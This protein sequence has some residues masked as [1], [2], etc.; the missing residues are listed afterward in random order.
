MP[1]TKQLLRETRDRIVPPPDVLGSLER[2]RHHR[3]QI[4]RGSALVVA[5]VVALLGLGGWFAVGRD[6]ARV[7][8]NP[9]TDL[10]IFDDVR[11]WIAYG[12]GSRIWAMDPATPDADPVVLDDTGGTPLAWSIDGSKLLVF[13]YGGPR[14]SLIVLNS[15]G[16]ET[17]LADHRPYWFPGGSF[18]PDGSQ[19]VYN[20]YAKGWTS[21]IYVVDAD[22]GTPR[23][24]HTAR[25][26]MLRSTGS[27]RPEPRPFQLGVFSPVVSPDGSQ[28]AYVEGMG[29][30][31]NSLWV[32]N[33]D[34]THQR[35]II[36]DKDDLNP[37]TA[38]FEGIGNAPILQWSPDGTRLA[39]GG[40]EG[41]YVVNADGS[42]LAL[43][44]RDVGPGP[45]WSPDGTRIAF[46]ALDRLGASVWTVR[47]DGSE[48]HEVGAGRAGPWN[49]LDPEY[50]DG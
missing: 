46:T 4:R 11:G 20:G 14:Q 12:H 29:D 49:P 32:M 8:A 45:Y 42:E 22:G 17:L 34:G 33:A 31:A 44:A 26:A 38:R 47:R 15:D 18:M 24:L 37:S 16:T 2:R 40:S 13:R 7:P 30:W 27:D 35:Q 21:G 9:P 5:I 48:P 1:D 50:G 3:D 41:I 25:V 36:G 19:V 10:G 23:L 39:F 28:I 43:V 6:A